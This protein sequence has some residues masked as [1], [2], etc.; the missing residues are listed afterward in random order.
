MRSNMY[1]D[2]VIAEFLTM[3]SALYLGGASEDPYT[4][5]LCASGEFW[6]GLKAQH[7]LFLAGEYELF[8]DDIV[9]LAEKVKVST[10]R[11]RNV[12]MGTL[13]ISRLT[14][15]RRDL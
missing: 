1:R 4:T 10:G 9:A 15:Q 5:P 11:F 6:R 14:T 8:V 7:L 3:A 13:T 2:Y 12:L